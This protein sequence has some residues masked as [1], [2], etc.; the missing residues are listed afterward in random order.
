MDERTKENLRKAV[1]EAL[2]GNGWAYANFGNDE[3]NDFSGRLDDVVLAVIDQLVSVSRDGNT[4]QDLI[5]IRNR[6]TEEK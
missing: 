6:I 2:G 5:G 1:H 4:Q 3:L